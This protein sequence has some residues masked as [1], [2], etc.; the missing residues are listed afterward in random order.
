MYQPDGIAAFD[1]DGETYLVTANE[2][3]TRGYAG[4]G[5]EAPREGSQARR[6]AASRTTRSAG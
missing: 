3:D 6:V 5:D 4:F 1:A 2:G